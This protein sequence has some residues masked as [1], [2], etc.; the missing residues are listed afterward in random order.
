MFW[1]WLYQGRDTY[2]GAVLIN[3]FLPNKGVI[4]GQHLIEG[5]T[6]SSK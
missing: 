5:G 6:Y 4:R 3:F 2:S 1:S